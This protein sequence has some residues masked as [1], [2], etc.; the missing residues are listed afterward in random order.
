[1]SAAR[2]RVVVATANESKLREIRAILADLEVEW[3]GLAEAGEVAFPEE[4]H[5]FRVRQEKREVSTRQLKRHLRYTGHGGHDTIS[6]TPWSAQAN[7]PKCN[8]DRVV[9]DSPSL[10][11][12]IFHAA[13]P[14]H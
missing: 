8:A 7:V 9:P 4:S 14:L 10:L 3:V 1:M 6:L 5:K 12:S 11:C 13:L 2:L